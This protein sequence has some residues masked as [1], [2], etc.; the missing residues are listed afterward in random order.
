MGVYR[1]MKS[2]PE[3][4]ER[5]R[6]TKAIQTGRGPEGLRPILCGKAE[7]LSPRRPEPQVVPHRA[8]RNLDK[9]GVEPRGSDAPDLIDA[10]SPSVDGL[11]LDFGLGHRLANLPACGAESGSFRLCGS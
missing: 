5:E 7:P 3:L 6:G 8:N 10:M 11:S 4:G 2:G 9:L 1:S